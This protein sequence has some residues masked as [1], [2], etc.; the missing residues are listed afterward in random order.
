MGPPPGWQNPIV[1]QPGQ[2]QRSVDPLRLLPSR[3]DLIK[4]RIEFQRGLILAGKQRYSLIQVTE[5]GVIYDGHH[6]V[7][8]AAEEQVNV[9]VLIVAVKLQPMA[10]SVLQLPVR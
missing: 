3:Q 10:A 7:R 8:A 9:D 4:L 1:V 2:T 6:G 5:D